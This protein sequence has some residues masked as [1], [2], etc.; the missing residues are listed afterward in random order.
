MQLLIVK[1]KKLKITKLLEVLKK[2]KIESK[3]AWSNID[4]FGYLKKFPSMINK[5]NNFFSK[6]ILLPSNEFKF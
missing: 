4:N 5:S 1:N 3:R 2:N 6:I